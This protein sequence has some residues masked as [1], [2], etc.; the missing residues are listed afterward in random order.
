MQFKHDKHLWM[1]KFTW[2]KG[3]VKL[4][5]RKLIRGLRKGKEDKSLSFKKSLEVETCSEM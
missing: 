2:R 1:E 4:K 3:Y 5:K